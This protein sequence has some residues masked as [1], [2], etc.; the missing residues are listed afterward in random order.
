[1]RKSKGKEFAVIHD[2]LVAPPSNIVDEDSMLN[3]E[4]KRAKEF[5]ELAKNND[6][7]MVVLN[8]LADENGVSN[9]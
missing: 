8:K 2:F 1:M 3:K 7:V 5:S 6:E 9:W 4:L